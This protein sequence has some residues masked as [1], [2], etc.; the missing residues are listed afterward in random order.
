VLE[1]EELFLDSNR[2]ALANLARKGSC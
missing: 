1:D 2:F